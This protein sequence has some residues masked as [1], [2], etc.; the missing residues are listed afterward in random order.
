MPLY[1]D[2]ARLGYGLAS[3][4]TD[5]SLADL[6]KLCDAFYIGGTKVGAFCGEA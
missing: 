2:G 1:L 3:H 6:A 5:V 4:Q